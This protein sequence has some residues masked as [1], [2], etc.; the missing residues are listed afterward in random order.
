MTQIVK[1]ARYQGKENISL[2]V[3]KKNNPT[4]NG[5]IEVNLPATIAKADEDSRLFNK[6]ASVLKTDDIK[7]ETRDF[8]TKD[9]KSIATKV[10]LDRYNRMGEG[11]PGAKELMAQVLEERGALPK[12]E[13]KKASKDKAHRSKAKKAEGAK[14]GSERELKKMLSDEEVAAQLQEARSQ[15]GQQVKFF[16]QKTQ[17]MEEGEIITARLDKRSNFIQFRIKITSGPSK[18]LVYGKGNDSEDIV[19]N[20]QPVEG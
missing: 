11:N 15:K 14:T 9:F 2:T 10:L 7:I 19:F 4:I 12:P 1:V 20:Q 3:S 16:C 8:T 5:Y 17:R 13:E 6:I 18:G